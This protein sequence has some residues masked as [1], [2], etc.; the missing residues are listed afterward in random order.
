MLNA[1]FL[2]RNDYY[3]IVICARFVLLAKVTCSFGI[4]A[5]DVAD[6]CVL[7]LL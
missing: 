6:N 7:L 5:G 3:N 2:Y 1:F 4:I